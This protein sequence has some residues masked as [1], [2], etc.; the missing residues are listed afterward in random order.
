MR[1]PRPWLSEQPRR[2]PQGRATPSKE[3]SLVMSGHS[4]SGRQAR[5]ALVC[6]SSSELLFEESED[7]VYVEAL[8]NLVSGRPVGVSQVTAV[9][10]RELRPPLKGTPY[11]VVFRAALKLPYAVRLRNP[12]RSTSARNS[13]TGAA[14]RFCYGARRID[15]RS[16]PSS[17]VIWQKCLLPGS[18]SASGRCYQ[19]L[20][21]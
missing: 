1:L 14:K 15:E 3:N 7:N 16:W 8:C 4:R 9:V 20:T 17:R 2:W 6:Q 21:S 12:S 19:S 11:P 18:R 13:P 10:R 5:Y